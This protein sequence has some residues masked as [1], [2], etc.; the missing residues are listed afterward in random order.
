[1]KRS[2]IARII[3]WS[4]T[5]IILTGILIVG[6]AAP[7]FLNLLSFSTGRS[8]NY[9]YGAATLDA[10]QID[11]VEIEWVSGDITITEKDNDKISFSETSNRDLK[12]DEQLGY[13]IEGRKLVIVQTTKSYWFG[14]VPSK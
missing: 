13:R 12:G 6:I 10:A 2:A 3:I 5:A 1:M 9:T 14:S 4:L 8:G 7:S 11:E